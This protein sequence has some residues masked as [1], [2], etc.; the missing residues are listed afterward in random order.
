MYTGVVMDSGEGVTDVVP[1]YEGY[2]LPH[3]IQRLKLAGK[4]LTEYLSKILTKEGYIFTTG[5]EREIVR[6]IKERLSYVALDFEKEL[7]LSR[8]A[9]RLDKRYELP[10]G[11]VITVGAA[12]FKCPEVLFDPSRIGIESGGVHEIVVSAIRRSDMDVRR[13]MFGNVV[14]SGG[15]SL[16]PGLADRMAKEL[17]ILAPPGVR[18]RVIAPPERKHSVWIGGSILASLSTFQQVFDSILYKMTYIDSTQQFQW[19]QMGVSDDY[20]GFNLFADVDY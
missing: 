7:A 13:E 18:V 6:D 8:E 4:D 10:D 14:V 11:Q 5:A 12:Q 9:S 3:A 19:L 16:L 1:I 20:Y 15:T 17:C 2:A